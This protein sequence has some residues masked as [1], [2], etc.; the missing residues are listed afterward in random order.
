MRMIEYGT[1]TAVDGGK[2]SS[3]AQQALKDQKAV[4]V[5][6]SKTLHAHVL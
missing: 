5:Y 4:D 2:L 3:A 6:N 1:N